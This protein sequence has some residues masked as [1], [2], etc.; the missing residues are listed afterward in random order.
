MSGSRQGALV[1]QNPVRTGL[2]TKPINMNILLQSA[3]GVVLVTCMQILPT[4]G[5]GRGA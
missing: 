5:S 3:G 4:A 1:G 2:R